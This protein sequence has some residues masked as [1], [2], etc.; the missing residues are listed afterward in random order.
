MQTSTESDGKSDNGFVFFLISS[1]INLLSLEVGHCNVQKN[2]QGG[3][4]K[5]EL[6]PRWSLYD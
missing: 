6:C 5:L 4:R 3:I 2:F 1:E